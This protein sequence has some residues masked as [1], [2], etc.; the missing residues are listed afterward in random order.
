MASSQ[1]YK[2]VYPLDVKSLLTQME[3]TRGRI[4]PRA[5]FQ[6][7]IAICALLISDFTDPV[8]KTD[9]VETLT[10]VA[11]RYSDQEQRQLMA[12]FCELAK[13]YESV[14]K[15]GRISDLLGNAY[16][17]LGLAGKMGQ[18]FSPDSIPGIL[19]RVTLPAG[20]KLPKAGFFTILEPACGSGVLALDTAQRIA[21]LGFN[22]CLH[23]AMQASDVDLRC[24][25]ITY[26]QLALHGFPAVVIHGN[27]LTL[28]EYSRWYTPAYIMGKWVWRCPMPFSSGR[29]W[30]DELLKMADEPTYGALRAMEWGLLSENG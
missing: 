19:S 11:E 28:E 13:H 15:R 7:F 3:L 1:T 22:P 30:S 20:C 21:D 14:S 5:V 6:D 24:V 10:G 29:N 8:H 9:R 23:M 17:E 26:M 25:Y 16:T 27:T 4:M 18:D 12:T 2:E